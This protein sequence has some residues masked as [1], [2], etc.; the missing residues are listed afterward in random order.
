MTKQLKFKKLSCMHSLQKIVHES[1]YLSQVTQ[2]AVSLAIVL[3]VCNLW[4]ILKFILESVPS[5]ESTA[6]TSK[7]SQITRRD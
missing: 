7:A 1:L 2:T 3:K 4:N 5:L 6:K